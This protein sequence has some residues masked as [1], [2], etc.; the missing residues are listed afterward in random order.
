MSETG[1]VPDDLM[2]NQLSPLKSVSRSLSKRKLKC[3]SKHQRFNL[4]KPILALTP[5]LDISK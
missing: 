5:Q 1:K 3:F 4:I 2:K